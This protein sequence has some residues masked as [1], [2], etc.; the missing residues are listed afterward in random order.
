MHVLRQ[1]AEH[2]L[3]HPLGRGGRLS[4]LPLPSVNGHARFMVAV[5]ADTRGLARAARLLFA[6]AQPAGETDRAPDS[7]AHLGEALD[8]MVTAAE[9]AIGI[10]IPEMSRSQKQQVVKY[11]DDRGAFLIKKAVEDVAGRLGVSRFTIY[12]YLDEANRL[13]PDAPSSKT[14]GAS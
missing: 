13:R 10:P 9:D 5:E 7:G 6:M 8:R 3:N 11:L 14:G 1:G 12:N 2:L 4:L